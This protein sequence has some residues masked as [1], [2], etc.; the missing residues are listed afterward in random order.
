MA[1]GKDLMD[2]GP[3]DVKEQPKVPE[4]RGD[5]GDSSSKD[6]GETECV[7]YKR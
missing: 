6:P 7:H 4:W 5:S 1:K 3:G 2:K